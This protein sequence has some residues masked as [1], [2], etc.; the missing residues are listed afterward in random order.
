VGRVVT[1]DL[2]LE[3]VWGQEYLGESHMLQVN[4]H[5]LHR[6]LEV[7]ATQSTYLLSK[8]GLGYS[9]AALPVGTFD[10]HSQGVVRESG[11]SFRDSH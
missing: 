6:T 2:L 7:D 10:V 8:V 3:Q 1:Q 4:I 5:R 9:L 11:P